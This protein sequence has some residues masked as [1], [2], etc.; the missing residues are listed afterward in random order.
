MPTPPPK[1]GWLNRHDGPPPVLAPLR[2]GIRNAC[3]HAADRG[4]FGLAPLDTHLVICGFPRSGTTLLQLMLETS[5]PSA[6]AF[7]RE[8]SG[9]GVARYTWPGRHEILVSKKPN[10]I[11]WVDDI[12][13]YYHGRR[14]KVRFLIS[15][16]DPRA[17]LTSF[18]VDKPGYCVSPDKWRAVYDHVLYQQQYPDVMV[19]DYRDVVD[20]P[21]AVRAR[22]GEFLGREITASFDRFHTAV[23]P[24]FDTRALNGV[25][26]LDRTAHD[27][28]RHERHFDR[29]RHLLH[30]MPEL[31]ERVIEMGHETD[32]NWTH[33]YV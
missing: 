3:I 6:L 28:W 20:R 27:K 11:F 13:S 24:R 22:V 16:R 9:L 12:R 8:R 33:D 19:V 32:R 29:I 31:P 23:P 1:P 5:I 26:P 7:G 21:E 18:F 14:P 30:E 10:D 2:R 15:Q 25:R 17:V 4:W